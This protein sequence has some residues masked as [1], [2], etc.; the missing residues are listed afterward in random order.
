[1]AKKTYTHHYD[2]RILSRGDYETLQTYKQEYANA[3]TDEAR[4]SAN[5]KAEALRANYGY[6]MGADGATFSLL[7]NDGAQGLSQDTQVGLLTQQQGPESYEPELTD[8]LTQLQSRQPFAY[9]PETDAVYQ[10]LQSLYQTQGQQAMRDTMGQA[11]SLTGGYG[12]SYAQTAGQ[13]AYQNSLD[14]LAQQLPQLYSLAQRSYELEGQRLQDQADVIGQLQDNAVDRYNAQQEHWQSMA[15]REQAGYWN[16]AQMDAQAQQLAYQQQADAQDAARDAQ[17][18]QSAAQR[19]AWQQ[20]MDSI[21]LG[22]V[23]ASAILTAA[24]ISPAWAQSMAAA[25]RYKIY[26]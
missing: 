18:A 11:A 7:R 14:A 16:Q 20:A 26:K 25:A 17:S 24:G 2:R 4:R 13:Q 23:P 3:A 6:S 19:N 21:A 9:D 1:M 5:Q 12:S 10:A 22:V 8:V 15:D